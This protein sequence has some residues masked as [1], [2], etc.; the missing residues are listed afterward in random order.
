MKK[1]KRLN[2]LK[3]DKIMN[4]NYAVVDLV[5]YNDLLYKSIKAANIWNRMYHIIYD[6]S[7]S[8]QKKY[9]KLKDILTKGGE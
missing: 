8:K 2:Q 6:S 1:I 5:S 4:V 9:D 7:L 3:N